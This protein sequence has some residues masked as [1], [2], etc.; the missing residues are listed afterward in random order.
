M[1]RFARVIFLW[2]CACSVV[3]AV[4][5]D[6]GK[7]TVVPS[8]GG[9]PPTNDTIFPAIADQSLA[10]LGRTDGILTLDAGGWPTCFLGESGS[11]DWELKKCSGGGAPCLIREHQVD[12]C[13][14]IRYVGVSEAGLAKFE[15]CEKDWRNSL[16]E[17]DCASQQSQAEQPLG[18]QVGP[19]GAA[20]DCT[21]CTMS[22]C[23]C[24]TSPY[25]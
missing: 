2:V 12:C 5:C 20:V 10:D 8:D 6:G 17:C 4:A 18:A 22:S 25:I 11:V 23:V 1:Q 16:P 24:M 7:R 19:D 9:E 3:W 15:A 13:G 14:T 21:N